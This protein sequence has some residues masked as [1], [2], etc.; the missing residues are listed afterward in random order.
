MYNINIPNTQQNNIHNEIEQIKKDIYYK[1]DLRKWKSSESISK[2]VNAHQK[3][4]SKKRNKDGPFSNQ[5]NTK[6][7]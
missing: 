7:G 2:W 1:T 5:R 4:M 6:Y 3:N